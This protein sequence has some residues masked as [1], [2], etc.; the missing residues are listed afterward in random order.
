[1]PPLPNFSTIAGAATPPPGTFPQGGSVPGT[2]SLT[3][4]FQALAQAMAQQGRLGQGRLRL[5]GDQ[6][7]GRHLGTGGGEVT[8]QNPTGNAA[9]PWDSGGLF[10]GGLTAGMTPEAKIGLQGNSAQAQL[11][12]MGAY[13][14]VDPTKLK[15]FQAGMTPTPGSNPMSNLD[16]FSDPFFIRKQQ[17]NPYS[18]MF[19]GTPTPG[20]DYTNPQVRRATPV[21]PGGPYSFNTNPQL[22]PGVVASDGKT[23]YTRKGS[24]FNFMGGGS[25]RPGF[26]FGAQ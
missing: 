7:F 15:D 23:N 17:G 1:M 5:Q 8:P 14:G 18:S 24:S 10:H 20:K 21:G 3:P 4:L 22:P 2:D 13:S 16:T 26:G 11:A 6:T 19:S 9:N 12:G 25:P